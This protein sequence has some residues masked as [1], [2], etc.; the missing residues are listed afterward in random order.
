MRLHRGPRSGEASE[1]KHAS[2]RAGTAATVEMAATAWQES[3]LRCSIRFFIREAAIR[4][5]SQEELGALVG[6]SRQRVNQALRTAGRVGLVR[7]RYG[8][9]MILDFE[10][11]RRFEK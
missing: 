7:L 9:L 8:G 10:G 6:L 1:H 11:L 2:D 5:V 4:S 3:W